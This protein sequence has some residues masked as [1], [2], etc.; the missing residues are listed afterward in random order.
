[1]ANASLSWRVGECPDRRSLAASRSPT[2]ATSR[3]RTGAAGWERRTAPSSRQ[4]RS[5]N[6][7]RRRRARRRHGSALSEDRPLF[8]FAG[9]WT[10]WRGVRGPKSAPVEVEHEL[11]G[12]LTTE[13][14]AIVAPVHPKAMP[15]ILT[16]IEEFDLWLEGDT[17]EA[18]TLQRPCR[19]TRSGSSRRAKRRMRRLRVKNPIACLR[20]L[21]GLPLCEDDAVQDRNALK[22]GHSSGASP[23]GSIRPE[24]DHARG[25]FSFI[26]LGAKA[27]KQPTSACGAPLWVKMLTRVTSVACSRR[28]APTPPM[29][30]SWQSIA[31]RYKLFVGHTAIRIPR[32]FRLQPI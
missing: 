28:L 16:T 9:L 18:L 20:R 6:M 2:S 8:A 3:V 30:F 29:L 13:A 17:V 26:F 15:V 10:R 5:A 21:G 23:A 19:T 27:A 7:R 11:F 12:F 25:T 24:M 32:I 4:R 1:M 22:T 14:N 31:F